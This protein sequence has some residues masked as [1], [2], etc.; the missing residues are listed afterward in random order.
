M[1]SGSARTTMSRQIL[2]KLVTLPIFKKNLFFIY[3]S[4]QSEVETLMLLRRCL[5]EGKSVCVPL[6]VP[7]Q[8]ELLAVTITDPSAD[9]LPG[10]KGIPEPIPSLVERQ[11][12]CPQSIDI[13]IIPGAVFD[14]SGHRLGY[15]GGYYDRFLAH[16]APQAC[17]VGLAFSHQL[18][19]RIPVLSH[20]IPLDMLV[21]E[22]EV[23]VW[24]RSEN[25]KNSCL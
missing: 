14:R 19:D 16:K 6:A 4:Y 1:L 13:A 3:C 2:E 22:N 17:R 21:T 15:G 25:E 23:L 5:D 12:V 8:S 11:R 9:L 10:Y 18:V 24:P 20:D 7:P